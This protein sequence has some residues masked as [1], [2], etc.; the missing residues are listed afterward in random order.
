VPVGELSVGPVVSLDHV[1][2]ENAIVYG[3]AAG[4]GF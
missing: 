3:L 4:S 1:A 2:G